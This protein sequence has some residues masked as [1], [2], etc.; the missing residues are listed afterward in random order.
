MPSQP[1]LKAGE[2]RVYNNAIEV[3][4]PSGD[5][6]A[7]HWAWLRD[8]CECKRCRSSSGQKLFR[9]EHFDPPSTN[10]GLPVPTEDGFNVRWYDGHI[11]QYSY[12]FLEK[13]QYGYDALKA[14][15]KK[16]E[17]PVWTGEELRKAGG[18]PTF[19]YGDVLSSDR[20]LHD[21]LSALDVRGL[22]I[23]NG[24]PLERGAVK[25][26]CDRIE[27]L[28]MTMYGPTWDVESIPNP[29]NVAYTSLPL[30]LH[31]D[32]CYYEVPPGV[33]LLHCIKFEQKTGGVNFFADAFKVAYDLKAQNP[34]AFNVLASVP[35]TFHKNDEKYH[36]EYAHPII[37][38]QH[39]LDEVKAINWSPPFEGIQKIPSEFVEPYYA[40]RRA[41]SQLLNQPQYSIERRMAPGEIVIFNNRRVLH[42]RTAFDETAGHRLLEGGYIGSDE[43]TNKLRVLKRTYSP[44]AT[45][46]HRGSGYVL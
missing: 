23:L 15:I 46:I 25:T 9:I 35:T 26:L 5:T 17:T 19:K 12:Q 13:H 24:A 7:F 20:S 38:L 32:L 42:A 33:Q 18:I 39:P 30:P 3:G 8:H 44:E 36:L 11:S 14:S 6:H 40:A 34:N 27:Y 43:W 21:W 29:N 28:R 4:L 1:P 16:T 10:V 45:H 31:A 2:L 22:T 41:W 37:E